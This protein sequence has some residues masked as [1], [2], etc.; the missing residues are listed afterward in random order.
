MSLA[1]PGFFGRGAPPQPS[2][3]PYDNAY[4]Y[5]TSY[6]NLH[7][8]AGSEVR[9]QAWDLQANNQVT[10][11]QPSTSTPTPAAPAVLTSKRNCLKAVKKRSSTVN[12]KKK[13]VKLMVFPILKLKFDENLVRKN[14]KCKQSQQL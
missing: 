3:N 6:W 4:M 5:P 10:Q 7:Y 2:A 12:N 13:V 8:T 11:P 1:L 14:Q 9:N